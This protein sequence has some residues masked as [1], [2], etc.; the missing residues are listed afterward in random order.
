MVNFISCPGSAWARA[1]CQALSGRPTRGRASPAVRSQAEPGTERILVIYSTSAKLHLVPRLCL[2]TRCLPGSAW[3]PDA[4]QRLAGSAVPGG[5]WDRAYSGHLF[6]QR[7][8][9]PPLLFHLPQR[10]QHGVAFAVEH[11]VC[12]EWNHM[13]AGQDKVDAAFHQPADVEVIGVEEARDRDAEHI[14][15]R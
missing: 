15:W 11:V 4:R 12:T 10:R 3:P 8:T 5:A 9:C 14:R 1:V 13:P 2:G 7:Q 6:H